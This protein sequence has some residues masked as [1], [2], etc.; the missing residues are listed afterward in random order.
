MSLQE[1][2]APYVEDVNAAIEAALD[3]VQPVDLQRACRHV[4]AAGGK[5]LRPV[6]ALLAAEAVGGDPDD[7]IPFAVAVELVHTFSLIHDDMMDEDDRRRG[8]EA[9]HRAWDH[10]TAILAG[11]TLFARSFEVLA[12][13]DGPV[14]VLLDL[15]RELARATRTICEGQARDLALERGAGDEDTYLT[16]IE[17][18]TARIFEASTRGGGLAGGADPD[19][20]DDLGAYGLHVGMAFQIRDDLLDV[21]ARE[22]DLGKPVASDVRAGKRTILYLHARAQATDAQQE[23]LDGAFGD[24]DATDKEIAA[25]RDVFEETGAVDHAQALVDEHTDQALEALES[26][27]ETPARER[28]AEVARWAAQRTH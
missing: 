12:D 5:R 28:L 6:M 8:R 7:A 4:P 22:E 26:L 1:V 17:G 3:P 9:V 18:K 20:A 16:M 25:V 10:D 15:Q 24:P 21:L 11:D 13:A 27:P 14:D 23:V 2:L 19:V